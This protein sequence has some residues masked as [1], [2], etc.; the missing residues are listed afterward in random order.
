[1]ST[2]SVVFAFAMVVA[3][4]AV[5]TGCGGKATATGAGGTVAVTEG[6]IFLDQPEYR[7]TN[8][9]VR[10]DVTN[11]GKLHHDLRV[12]NQQYFVETNPGG[13]SS[14]TVTLPKGTYELFCSIPGHEA[15]KAKLVVE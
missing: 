15:A 12:R 1:M 3:A 11:V 5:L 9:A 14:G 13:K 7:V 4:L 10:I 8:G 6:D 2:R